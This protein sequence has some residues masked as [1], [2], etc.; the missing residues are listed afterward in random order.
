MSDL[1]QIALI[2]AMGSMFPSIVASLFAYRS[3]MHSKETLNVAKK[4][5]KNTN[6]MKDE[7]VAL[8]NKESYA[9]GK[10]DQ[11]ESQKSIYPE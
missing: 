2:S 6:S 4:T 5:E 1:V 7:L 3:S 10:F 11:K 9:R 8:T